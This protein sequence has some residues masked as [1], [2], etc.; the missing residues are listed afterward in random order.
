MELKEHG[1]RFSAHTHPGVSDIV[2]DASGILGDR[3][4]L[5]L[6]DQE[7]SLILNAAGPRNVF[8]MVGNTRI[9]KFSTNVTKLTKLKLN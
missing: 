5:V 7:R 1:F 3:M 2:L 4:V 8:D 9:T 6:M